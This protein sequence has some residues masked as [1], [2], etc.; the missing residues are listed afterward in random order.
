MRYLA[1]IAEDGREQT[2]AEH[3]CGTARLR[4]IWFV[5]MQIC[6]KGCAA[7]GDRNVYGG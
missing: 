3:L 2:V 4:T 6:R 7:K 1:H 5:R